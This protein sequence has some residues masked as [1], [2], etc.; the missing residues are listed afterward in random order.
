MLDQGCDR[1]DC[2]EKEDLNNWV[3]KD[4]WDSCD[5]TKNKNN[6]NQLYFSRVALDSIKY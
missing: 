6:N 3:D 4:E 1:F 5:N 2:D